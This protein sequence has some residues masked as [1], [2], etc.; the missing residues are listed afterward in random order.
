MHIRLMTAAIPKT[1]WDVVLSNNMSGVPLNV[2]LIIAL[3]ATFCISE[4]VVVIFVREGFELEHKPDVH[5]TK[6]FP[7]ND[8]NL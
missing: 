3:T 8:Q 7:T 1:I 4:V 6:S 2:P 5:I